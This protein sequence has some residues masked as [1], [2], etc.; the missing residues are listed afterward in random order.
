MRKVLLCVIAMLLLG[1]SPGIAAPVTPDAPQTLQP[2]DFSNDNTLRLSA[3]PAK[4]V[5]HAKAANRIK[6]AAVT[7]QQVIGDYIQ[8]SHSQS[9]SSV[10]FMGMI[11]IAAGSSDNALKINNFYNAGGSFNATLNPAQGTI[12]I[13]SGQ[14]V[15]TL[16]D[17]SVLKLY[18][19][20]FTLNHYY[21]N[22]I[23]ARISPKGIIYFPEMLIVAT[24][25]TSG[26]IRCYGDEWYRLNATQTDY[27]L[28]QQGDKAVNTYKVHYSRTATTQFLI[29]HFYG[30]GVGISCTVDTTGKAQVPRTLITKGTTTSG[31]T[32]NL[33][34]YN[35]TKIDDTKTPPVPTLNSSACTAQFSGDS[36]VIG[37]WCLAAGTGSSSARADLLSKS[38]IRV[39]ASEAWTNIN[40]GLAFEGAGTKENPFK[41]KTAQD[42]IRLSDVGNL[43]TAVLSGKVALK[44]VYFEQTADIDM[45]EVEA[46]DPIC[47]TANNAF[48]GHYNGNGHTITGLKVNQTRGTPYRAGLFGDLAAGSSVTNLILQSPVIRSA[49]SYVGTIAG[50]NAGTVRNITLNNADIYDGNLNASY[51]GGICGVIVNNAV[52]EDCVVNGGSITGNDFVGSV[53]GNNNGAKVRRV[54]SSMSVVRLPSNT[55]NPRI[56]GLAGCATRDTCLYEDCAFTGTIKLIGHEIAGGLIG[57]PQDGQLLRCWFGGQIMHKYAYTSSAKIGGIVGEAK[58][59]RITDCHVSGIVQSYSSPNVGGFIGNCTGSETTLSGNLFTGTLM[60]SGD[61]KANEFA[62]FTDDNCTIVNSF[63]DKQTSSNRGTE[64]GLTTAAL[65]SGTLPAGLTAS[66]WTVQSGKYPV[67]T[68]AK[69]QP[70]AQL[71]AV[72]FFLANNEDIRGIRS[73]FTLG[74]GNNTAWHFFHNGRYTDNGNGLAIS[75]TNVSITATALTSDTLVAVDPTGQLFRM[76]CLKVTPKEFSGEGT[77]ASPFIIRNKADMDRLFNAVDNHLYDYTDTYFRL[78]GDIDFSGVSAFSGY[79]HMAPAYAFNG[80]LD[81]NGHSI[82]NLVMPEPTKATTPG[83]IFVYT[84]PQSVIKNFVIADNCH[85]R[86]GSYA[87]FVAQS[88]GLLQNIVNLAPVTAYCD[89]AAGIACTLAPTSKVLDCYNAGTIRAGRENAA[90]IASQAALGSVIANCQNSGNV[91]CE[92]FNMLN[93]NPSLL[94]GAAGITADSRAQ[95][96]NCLNQG[97]IKGADCVGGIAGDYQGNDTTGISNCIN[98]GVIV[99]TGNDGTRGGII[100]SS[101]GT[102]SLQNCY[103]D[104]QFGAFAASA[105]AARE[106]ITDLN[107][108]ELTNGKALKGLSADVWKFEA[109]KYPVLKQFAAQE[110]SQWYAATRVEFATDTRRETRFDKRSDALLVMPQGSTAKLADAKVF[111]INGNRITH[112]VSKT[113]AI[114]TLTITSANGKY[115]VQASLFGTPRLLDN[116]NGTAADPWIINNDNDWNNIAVFTTDYHKDLVGEYFRLGSDIKF[117]N[118]FLPFCFDGSTFFQG[119]LDGNGKRISGATYDDENVKYIGLISRGGDKAK[120]FNLVIDST[121]NFAGNQYVGGVAGVFGGE[122][123]NITNHGNMTTVKM[124]Y[125]GGVLGSL[126]EGGRIHDCVNYGTMNSKSNGAGGLVGTAGPKTYIESCTNHGEIISGGSAG[127]VVGSTK[128]FVNLCKNYGTV[129]ST[130][131][132][133]GGIVGYIWVNDTLSITNCENFGIVT[134]TSSNCGGIGGSMQGE[135]SIVDCVNHAPITGASSNVG[136]ILGQASSSNTHVKLL[137]LVNYGRVEGTSAVGGVIGYANSSPQSNPSILDSLINYGSVFTTKSQYAGGIIGNSNTWNELYNCR[138]YCDTVFSK[139]YAAGGIAGNGTISI[140]NCYNQADV[141]STT[142]SVGGILGQGY[143]GSTSTYNR[144]IENCVNTGHVTSLG[145]TTSNSKNVGGIA[146]Y[147]SVKVLNSANLG[148]VTGLMGVGGILGTP[149]KGKDANNLGS[150]ILNCYSAGRVNVASSGKLNT[151]GMIHGN[152][153]TT[154]T[155]I[156]YENNFYD[157]QMAGKTF[158]DDYCDDES[159]GLKTAALMKANLGN[160]FVQQADGYPV[161]KTL[162]AEPFAPVAFANIV[163]TAEDNADNVTSSFHVSQAPGLVWEAKNMTFSGHGTAQWS[164]ADLTAPTRLTASLNGAKRYAML[165]LCSNVGADAIDTDAEVSSVMWYSLSGTQLAAPQQGV[166]IRVT[167]FTNGTSRS[168]KVIVSDNAQ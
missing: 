68:F 110:A 67:L 116:G 63:Y 109:G 127:G 65:T 104:A 155:N 106:G 51:I 73:N 124:Q 160:G 97:L 140:F 41:I 7:A 24:G 125:A 22:P 95:I 35:V 130:S 114:D 166:N 86:G 162:A 27:S 154:P 145:S 151:C 148:D 79:S 133:G 150:Q 121:V 158:A 87:G 28:W 3:S 61:L 26:Q 59:L 119:I 93:N 168:E 18:L 91:Y 82:R 149:V 48:G 126:D 146:G 71:D 132:S 89:N 46:F 1:F 159:T 129:T 40:T 12:T 62:G 75:G 115:T 101:Y 49:N 60:V 80:I 92:L 4:A 36:I 88:Y 42:L 81:G 56:G 164:S 105:N 50:N 17:G 16:Q 74:T 84:G 131:T 58:N 94:T 20:N 19:A 96:T 147:A 136:G 69:D 142:Y 34:N 55:S 13:Q 76:Y 163:L 25:T 111:A 57:S 120:V 6:L 152:A 33:Y 137:R 38:V 15:G 165:Q 123:Y 44:D 77:A 66:A 113:V 31:S 98:T 29:K 70:K 103:F 161:I 9:A 156:K 107:T 45:T 11:N 53:N 72:P 153:S 90:G 14:T 135:G 118:N 141:I 23:V 30:C 100:G 144:V 102:Y 5:Y 85:L 39:P 32:V 78:E 99:E 128:G 112:P 43:N 157:S 52:I 122:V 143:T 21:N 54:I 139:S 10:S 134:A 8:D 117:N 47:W 64:H 138:N 108:A 83:A 167:I 37:P 2:S